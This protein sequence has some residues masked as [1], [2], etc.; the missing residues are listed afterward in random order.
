MKQV[1]CDGYVLNILVVYQRKDCTINGNH[2]ISETT[3]TM[4]RVTVSLPSMPAA[5]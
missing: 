1:K 3:V 5:V 4:N 2:I